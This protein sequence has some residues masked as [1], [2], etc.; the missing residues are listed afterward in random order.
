MLPPINTHGSSHPILGTSFSPI[1]NKQGVAKRAALATVA[2]LS[3]VG[4]VTTL[5][6][7]ITLA[8]P[9][10]AAA[11]VVFSIIAVAC[12]V[13]L[14][15]K[16]TR[17]APLPQPIEEEIPIH[18]DL[19]IPEFTPPTSLQPVRETE[20]EPDPVSTPVETPAPAPT[21]PQDLPTT[22]T[23]TPPTDA[24]ASLLPIPSAQQLLN[25]WTQLPSSNS[26]NTPRFDAIDAT[27]TF[28]GWKF[29]NTKTTLVSTC[30][31]I[32][33]PRFSTTGLRP[34]LVNAANATMFKNGSGTNYYFTRAVSSEGWENSKENKNRLQVGECSAGKWINRDGTNNDNKPE[35]PAFLAQLLGPT[36]NQLN[37]SSERC[38]EVITQAYENCLAKAL[39]K[40]SKYVQVPLLSSNAFAPSDKLVI[41]G[42]SARNLW[43]DA[44]KA[45]LV[46]AAQNFATQN[47]NAEI[48]IVVTDIDNPPLG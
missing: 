31:D 17:V 45:A 27:T 9:A 43:I 11:V 22:A 16:P 47:P 12:C 41:N 48:I 8:M 39:Q 26:I 14:N 20:G 40:G 18:P 46:T 2:A 29:P 28:K 19:T 3:L 21:Q 6:L 10:L 4:F 32:T 33:K 25:G 42:R 15:K 13:L 5:A 36:A 24:P 30:G 37:N 38:Y 35:G 44:V 34:M 23:Q 1:Q 7:A